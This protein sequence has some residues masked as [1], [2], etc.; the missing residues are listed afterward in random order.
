ML[1]HTTRWCIYAAAMGRW[2]GHKITYI[3]TYICN[4]LHSHAQLEPK[5]WTV[6][7]WRRLGNEGIK[8]KWF[9]WHLNVLMGGA[10]LTDSG[11]VFQMT[12]DEWENALW[13]KLWHWHEA[14]LREVDYWIIVSEQVGMERLVHEGMPDGQKIEY[15]WSCLWS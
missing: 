12:G 4:A 13:P 3:H 7:R 9:R 1:P 15:C 11:I 10:S 6:T 14:Q 2:R 8:V 5:A